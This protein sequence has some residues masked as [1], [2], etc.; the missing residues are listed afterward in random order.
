MTH[1]DLHHLHHLRD[2]HQLSDG[3]SDARRSRAERRRL[4]PLGAL[5][6][7][8]LL[9][10]SL[11]S[12]GGDDEAG[13]TTADVAPTASP[14]PTTGAA[15]V[16]DTPAD[17]HDPDPSAQSG[18]TQPTNTPESTVPETDPTTAEPTDGPVAPTTVAL[19][20]VEPIDVAPT[21]TVAP[22]ALQT[23]AGVEPVTVEVTG[24]DATRPIL[25]WTRPTSA[26]AFQ[27]VV[28][29]TDGTP[30]WAWTGATTSVVLGGE[31]RAAN[32]EGPSLATGSRVRVYAFDAAGALVGVS[33]W[34]GAGV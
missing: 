33:A 7:T 4:R 14:A 34:T 8:P 19:T 12:C 32:V 5:A 2:V 1:L 11:A 13:R 27:L 30:M 17:P 24:D 20:T 18:A 3:R 21:T 31:A 10:L 22:D 9:L 23:S 6:A 28:Q 16:A 29:T 25:S 15:H 26:T